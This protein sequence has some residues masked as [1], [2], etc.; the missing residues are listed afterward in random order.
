MIFF[1]AES[2]IPFME[3]SLSAGISASCWGNF[4]MVKAAVE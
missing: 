4:S 2:P 1:A 3:L